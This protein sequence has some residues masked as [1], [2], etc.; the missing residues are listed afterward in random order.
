MTALEMQFAILCR[1]QA[2]VT[3]EYV[4]AA[5]WVRDLA[6]ADTYAWTAMPL[7]AITEAARSIPETATL[8]SVTLPS[9]TGFW[10]LGFDVTHGY[11]GLCWTIRD[12][13]VVDSDQS[14]PVLYL[15]QFGTERPVPAIGD[16]EVWPLDHS[17]AEAARATTVFDRAGTGAAMRLFLA[18]CVWLQQ[19]ILVTSAGHIE[20]HRRKQL[21]REHA[22]PP[23]GDVKI[24]ELRRRE[25]TSSSTS[26]DTPPMEWSCQWVVSGH[27]THQVCGPKGGERRLQYVLPYVKG[28]ADK[29]LRVPSHTVYQVDR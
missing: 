24:I 18:G 9:A 1:V 12:C 14:L 25:V 8:S 13:R 21:A 7:H 28:P 27:W 4:P 16:T 17:L 15:T 3:S 26:G 5:D 19:R 20:R 6:R 22:I 10:W 11:S 2:D 23:P 29:P